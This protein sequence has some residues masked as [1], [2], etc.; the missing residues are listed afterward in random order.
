MAKKQVVAD[1][2]VRREWWNTAISL[3]SKAAPA[4]SEHMR[5]RGAIV[6]EDF[7]GI[8]LGDVPSTLIH[9]KDAA[10]KVVMRFLIPWNQIV[11][12]GI[13]DHPA[14]K[15]GFAAE[16]PSNDPHAARRAEPT[17]V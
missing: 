5:V 13:I 9:T 12:I 11:A 6:I 1:L 4:M 2:I 7:Q 16:A 14:M 17:N 3:V 15:P 10:R 8:W